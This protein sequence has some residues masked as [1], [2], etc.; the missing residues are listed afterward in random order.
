MKRMT[1]R[2]V[3][4]TAGKA[5]ALVMCA[6]AGQAAAPTPAAAAEE[7][8]SCYWEDEF[9]VNPGF[10]DQPAFYSWTS[11]SR[12]TME[13]YG[14]LGGEVLAGEGWFTQIG[15]GVGTCQGGTGFVHIEGELQSVS[16]AVIEL[17]GDLELERVG[18]TGVSTGYLNGVLVSGPYVA[19]PST[20]RVGCSADNPVRRAT[21][22]GEVS[23]IP[24]GALIRSA[25][26]TQPS[27]SSAG[28]DSVRVTWEAAEETDP[29]LPVTGYR[30][31]RDDLMISELGPDAREL[32]DG[33]LE[34]GL[35]G[36]EVAA[37]NALVESE[38]VGDFVVAVGA[39]RTP[40]PYSSPRDLTVS[41]GSA[42]PAEA[43]KPVLHWQLPLDFQGELSHFA[44]YSSSS[45]AEP[46]GIGT[47]ERHD[48]T[49]KDERDRSPCCG[50]ISY[51]VTA[52]A[53]DGAEYWSAPAVL[54]DSSGGAC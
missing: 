51:W 23:S 27:A 20:E 31:Y 37:V 34:P 41:P 52:V 7:A 14:T 42:P 6:V 2:A 53:T 39:D 49:F 22:R 16:G 45:G 47:A 40:D 38:H 44:I 46:T 12:G 17:E 15:S 43:V 28:S 24:G 3:S 54:A 48:R 50:D 29:L 8:L 30:V 9:T 33:P 35:Y 10:S 1:R 4:V 21:L 36:Y 32:V 5:L 11:D 19:Q 13:C 25:P 26:P 18:L